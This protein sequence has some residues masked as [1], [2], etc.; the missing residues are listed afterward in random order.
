M[1][2]FHRVIASERS[3]STA[4]QMKPV[5]SSI[6]QSQKQIQKKF[7]HLIGKQNME[8]VECMCSEK[9]MSFSTQGSF[10]SNNSLPASPT[11]Y[12]CQVQGGEALPPHSQILW[13]VIAQ[14]QEN[15]RFLQFV[16]HV[17]H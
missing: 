14:R 5:F 7:S 6:G 15:A 17:Y 1:F 12:A 3:A 9:Q 11:S 16:L 10:A 4:F 2:N 13:N 8:H